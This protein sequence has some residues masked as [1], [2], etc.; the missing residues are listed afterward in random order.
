M[1]YYMITSTYLIC[2]IIA[3]Q[4]AEL[5]IISRWYSLCKMLEK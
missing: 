5:A 4:R 3:I 2:I 1:D